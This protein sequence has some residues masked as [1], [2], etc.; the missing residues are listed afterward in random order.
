MGIRIAIDRT[1]Q[2]NPVAHAGRQ[3]LI[4]RTSHEITHHA[5]KAQAS[6][7]SRQQGMGKDIHRTAPAR[8]A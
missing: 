6:I 4:W 1:V 8:A 2:V 3:R 5:A 7:V